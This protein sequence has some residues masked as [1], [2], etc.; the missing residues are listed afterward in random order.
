MFFYCVCCVCVCCDLCIWLFTSP[1][2]SYSLYICVS[3]FVCYRDLNIETVQAPLLAV[4]S[5]KLMF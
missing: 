1:E 3:N 2:E 5:Q 4:A